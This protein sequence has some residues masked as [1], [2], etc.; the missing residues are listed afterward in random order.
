MIKEKVKSKMIGFI[1][2]LIKPFIVPI[3]IILIL[4]S[5]ACSITD[6]LYIAF[7][8]DDKIDMKKELKYYDTEYEKNEMKDF[9]SSVWE[10]VEKI[11]GGG[12]MTDKT[13][14]PVERTI[15]NNQQFW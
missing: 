7:N 15:Y 6:V 1:I 9:F 4:L 2:L 5:I 14:W 12:E 8:H 10:F 13:D 3:M 11:F